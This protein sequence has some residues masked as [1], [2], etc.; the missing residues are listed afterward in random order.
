MKATVPPMIRPSGQGE[1]AG[2][3]VTADRIPVMRG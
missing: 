1:D 2:S 3:R